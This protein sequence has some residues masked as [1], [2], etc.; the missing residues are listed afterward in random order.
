MPVP[1]L[2][3]GSS[4]PKASQETSAWPPPLALWHSLL[5]HSGTKTPIGAQ[6]TQSSG[7]SLPGD[8][9]LLE[10]TQTSSRTLPES[11]AR[12]CAW[13]LSFL[14]VGLFQELVLICGDPHHLMPRAKWHLP[15]ASAAELPLAHELPREQVSETMVKKKLMAFQGEAQHGQKPGGGSAGEDWNPRE[16]GAK[17]ISALCP[18]SALCAFGASWRASWGR[19]STIHLHVL[20]Q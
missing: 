12:G 11:W 6:R 10:R 20:T 2:P 15:S 13:H 4:F 9:E 17:R 8:S 5:S 18:F 1:I 16:G 7:I 14:P 19:G 3:P